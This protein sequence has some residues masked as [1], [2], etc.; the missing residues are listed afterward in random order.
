MV[1]LGRLGGRFEG[2]DICILTDS[3][4]DGRDEPEPPSPV[5]VFQLS[6][7]FSHSG[8]TLLSFLEFK[9]SLVAQN[10]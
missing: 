4:L 10:P 5:C 8:I 6:A 7:L 3:R 2:E 1:E 9:K